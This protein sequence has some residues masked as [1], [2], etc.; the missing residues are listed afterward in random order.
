MRIRQW[1]RSTAVVLAATVGGCTYS[2]SNNNPVL[3]KLT[4]FSYVGGEDI[5]RDCKTENPDK[6][7][8]VYNAVW[9][10]Q[11]R[12]YDLVRSATGQ[13]ALL[14]TT[15]VAG[16]GLAIVELISPYAG[17]WGGVQTDRRLD[18]AQ[19]RALVAA[20]DQSG[21]SAPSP[22][23]LRLYSQRFYWVV[24]ACVGGRFRFNAWPYP[25]ERFNQIA[26]AAPLF[27]VDNSGVAINRPRQVDI[28]PNITPGY[29]VSD[30]NFELIVGANGLR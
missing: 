4:W 18:E 13:G 2:G 29:R 14:F 23:G 5:R 16:G 25:G 30:T 3:R 15:V 12:A 21:L 9:D 28:G 27:Q 24:S 20:I 8:L 17:P 19:Y 11:V 1:F 6:Y 10:E 7:R 26:F 22:D